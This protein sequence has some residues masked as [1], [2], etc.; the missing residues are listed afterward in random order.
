LP[1]D[2]ARSQKSGDLSKSEPDSGEQT[3]APASTTPATSG[4]AGKTI[5]ERLRICRGC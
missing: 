2:L 3:T 4:A 5:D 1:P